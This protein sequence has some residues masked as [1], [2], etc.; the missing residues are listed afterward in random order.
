MAYNPYGAPAAQ[1]PSAF[2]PPPQTGAPQPWEASEVIGRAWEIVKVHW[3]PLVFGMM[4]GTAAA[5]APQQVSNFYRGVQH[6][7]QFDLEDPV[8]IALT[9]G[10]ALFGWV[11]QAF[12]Q[13]GFTKMFITAARGGAPEFAQLFSG[14]PRFLAM[15]GGMLLHSILVILGFAL[16]VVPG[17]ILALGLTLYPYYIV[18]RG[19]GP[20]EALKASWDATMGHKGKLFVLGLY[21]L[22]VALVGLLA[23]CV[24]ML[25]AMA[26]IS[27]AQAV[28]YVRLTGT[29]GAAAPPAGYG[30]PPTYG[31]P[32]A[33][34]PPHG[35]YGP[36]PGGY[37][38]PPQGYGPPPGGYGPR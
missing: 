15:L 9:A 24:G 31:P 1:G 25:P 10:G 4:I 37:G 17:V 33:W 29:D 7:G 28:V 35:G 23:C 26:V 30:P 36:P 13:A 34:G 16:L 38:P 11:L 5:S 6:R 32:G 2:A 27:V 8:L 19:L 21:S 3:V 20:V 22:G 14:G 12:F 18:E